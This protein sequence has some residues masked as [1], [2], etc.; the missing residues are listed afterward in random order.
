MALKTVKAPPEMEPLF[1]KA[2]EVVAR[3]FAERHHDPSKGTIE[4]AG[5]RYVLVRAAALSVEFFALLEDLFGKGNEAKAN[6]FAR[7]ILFDLS[8][9][10]GRSDAQSFH[11]EMGLTDPIE[12]LSAGPV[13]FAHSGWAFV[14]ISPDSRPSPDQD[15]YMIYDH[16]F[17]FEADAWIQSGHGSEFPVCIM[18]AG[19]SSGWCENSFDMTLVA[20]EILCRARGDECCRFIMAPP[21]RIEEHIERYLEGKPEFAGK[22]HAYAIPD[23][24]ARKRIEEELR[25]AK[26]E[27]EAATV[28][29]S[30]FLAK[31][32]HEIR[33]PMNGVIGMTSLLLDTDLTLEQQEYA[34]ALRVSGEALLG[35]INDILDFSKIEAGKLELETIDFDLWRTVREAVDLLAPQAVEKGLEL[36]VTIDH[37]V[38]VGA[39]GDPGRFRQILIN[40]VG[41]AVKFTEKGDIVVQASLIDRTETQVTVR[42]SVKDPGI[43]IPKEQSA[44]LFDAFTQADAS[45]TRKHG[46]T[47]L[48]LAISKQ[49][50]ELMGGDVG[51]DSQEG[52][53]STFWFTAV[54]D[55]LP[56]PLADGLTDEQVAARAHTTT[57]Y[58]FAQEAARLRASQRHLR[59]LVAEDNVISQKVAVNM[60]R[61]FGYHADGV[62]NGVEAVE[63]VKAI[64]YDLVLMDCQ[65]PE[66]NGYE[67]TFA[68]RAMQEQD[69]HVPIVAM[70][71]HTMQGDREKCLEAGMDDYIG[72]PVDPKVLAGVLEKWLS[73]D[74][75]R[76]PEDV[77]E[78][79]DAPT[80][81][82]LD[83][84]D[85]L[86][87]T[88][89]DEGLARELLEEFLN[90]FPRQ[91]AALRTALEEAD[92]LLAQHQAHAIKGAAKNVGAA[93]LGEIASRAEAAAEASNLE[94]TASLM[95]QMEQ[96]FEAVKV[97]VQGWDLPAPDR[98]SF[99]EQ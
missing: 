83:M 53:G 39:R 58:S 59:V 60:L 11:T 3:Y 26:E 81:S 66:M 21:E 2:E 41:N 36:A 90:E 93:A 70:T 56:T 65:M 1:A 49:L 68:I 46:G 6:D 14:D 67:A 24:F 91:M 35:L 37:D 44:T 96:Q 28:A 7:N 86:N 23:F 47:G 15:Y 40:L 78:R 50:A 82:A 98:E 85:L 31:M 71:A 77:S 88:M 51:V 9:A 38:P 74:G 63:A 10:I 48:G 99:P 55:C 95:P 45:M 25:R 89:G 52:E 17:S 61:K 97:A 22:R 62:A 43:G 19:Y 27:A 76:A 16:P 94:Q 20:S 34:E 73:E 54:F 92:V 72:K 29:K 5:Q 18:N 79:H 33:T 42:L 69:R 64:P 75:A 87:R 32:S 84:S 8:H 57:R 12:R 80:D 13:H 4:I 30:E